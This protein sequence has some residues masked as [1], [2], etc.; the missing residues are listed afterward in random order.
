MPVK[1]ELDVSETA[2]AVTLDEVLKTDEVKSPSAELIEETVL[3]AE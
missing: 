3:E 1:V 2:V